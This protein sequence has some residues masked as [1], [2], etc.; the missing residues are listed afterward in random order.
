MAIFYEPWLKSIGQ[1][2]KR[3]WR[4]RKGDCETEHLLLVE[5]GS[6]LILDE[7]L[8]NLDRSFIVVQISK[9]DPLCLQRH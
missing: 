9:T 1:I 4:C 6:P 8:L 3:D 7:Q 5:F 2:G